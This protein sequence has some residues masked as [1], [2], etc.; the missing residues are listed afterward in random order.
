MNITINNTQVTV[1]SGETLIET[2][3]RT[4]YKIPSMCYAQGNIHKSSCMVCAVKN[5][6]TGQII[7]A[8][9]T[10]P[11]EGMQIET[12]NEEVKQVRRLSLELLLSDHRADCEA[13]C[14]LVC[15]KGLDIELMLTYYD[16][17][18]YTEAFAIIQNSFNLSDIRCNSCKAPCEKACRRGTIDVPVS[19][20]EIIQ[21]LVEEYESE[22]KEI[23]NNSYKQIEKDKNRYYSRLGRFTSK[24][25]EL[26]KKTVTTPSRCL[27]CAC[28]GKDNCKLRQY[29]TEEGLKRPRYES[30]SALPVMEKTHITG[31]LWF[32]Q[33][34]CIRC[35]LCVYNSDNGFTFKN[36]G[37][38]MQVVIP[39]ENK[40]NATEEL[41]GLCPTGA[42]YLITTER[43]IK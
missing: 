19:I 6:T 41:A 4:G 7:P 8:C 11:V 28:S 16:A 43:E 17:G 2:A 42:L 35:G 37:F 29:A 3:R 31:K 25:K 9:T 33:A 30:S 40:D 32:E 1:L 12:E 10:L 22:F 36:R 20:R 24:E 21:K 15:P 23:K 14:S 27:H 5:C 39:D 18:K 13:P 26:L 34:K 38:I